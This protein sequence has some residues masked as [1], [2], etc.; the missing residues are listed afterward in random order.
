MREYKVKVHNET[1]NVILIGSDSDVIKQIFAKT[2][3]D[4][5]IEAEDGEW[6]ET[7][8]KYEGKPTWADLKKIQIHE[9]SVL[10]IVDRNGE[11]QIIVSP[12]VRIVDK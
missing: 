10:R 6:K 5:A 11:P 12:T 9:N 3:T 8:V 1:P 7:C 2:S 4:V